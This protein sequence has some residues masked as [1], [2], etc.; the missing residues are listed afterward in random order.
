M[1]TLNGWPSETAPRV[2]TQP[3][4]VVL[5]IIGLFSAITA[6]VLPINQLTQTDA[7]ATINIGSGASQIALDTVPN[8]PL[9]ASLT[10]TSVDGLTVNAVAE[11]AADGGPV[12]WELR[13]LTDLGTSVWALALAVIAILLALIVASISAGNPFHA[14]NTGRLIGVSV[15]ILAGSFGADSVN[16]LSAH[17]L[18]DYLALKPPLAVS[19]YYS[20]TPVLM[21]ALILVLASAFR[22]GRQ[23]Q[24]DVE[25]LV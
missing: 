14:K 23:I 6:V 1:P 21:A 25:G 3:L 20:L 5:L 17:L 15:A 13:L 24:D 19:A 4:A 11:T 8:L 2:L 16:L 10:A 12:P 18:Y 7:A 9:N 22:R